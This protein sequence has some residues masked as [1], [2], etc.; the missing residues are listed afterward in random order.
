MFM[1]FFEFVFGLLEYIYYDILYVVL[2][3]FKCEEVLKKEDD[4][5][6]IMC[7]YFVF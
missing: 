4:S 6:I 1:L 2:V 7:V 3:Q 5:V